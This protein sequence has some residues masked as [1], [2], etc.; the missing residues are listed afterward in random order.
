MINC[1]LTLPNTNMHEIT[2]YLVSGLFS[3]SAFIAQAQPQNQSVSSLAIQAGMAG[4]VMLL[5]LKFFPMILSAMKAEADANRKVV[6]EIVEAGHAKDAA[7]QK[8]I[9][10]KKLCSK[11]NSGD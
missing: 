5:L 2:P 9:A 11:D 10:D 8:I 3:A 6:R 1:S 7:W 4:V